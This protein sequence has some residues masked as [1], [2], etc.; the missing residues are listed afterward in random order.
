[1]PHQKIKFAVVGCGYIGK[2]HLNI[3]SQHPE[4]ELTAIIDKDSHR[5][6][7]LQHLNIPSFQSVDDYL[8]SDTETDVVIV[9][10]PNGTHAS[11]AVQ[12]MNQQKHVLIEKPMALKKSDAEYIIQTAKQTNRKAMVVLQNRFSPVSAWLKQLIDSNLAGKIFFVEVNCFWNRDERYYKKDSWHGTSDMDG[13]TL[14]TQ[15]SHFIDTLYWLFGDI[16]NI[17]SRFCNFSHQHLTDFED[18]G[19]LH[20]EFE[21]GGLGCVNFSTA[22]WDKTMESNLTI[23]AENGTVKVSGQ[24]MDRIEYCH[25][26]NYDLPETI[27]AVNPSVSNHY[28]LIDAVV[29]A[30]KEDVSTNAEEALH[31]VDIIERMYAAKI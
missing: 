17:K 15:F 5:L 23:L 7:E 31:S 30:I 14:F 29:K 1:V 2:R 9:A 19:T 13:G 10:T 16:K 25:I 21:R 8:S 12:I 18:T 4:C 28:K 27:E 11:L 3:L 6:S 24:Y 20:F 22:L 26:K